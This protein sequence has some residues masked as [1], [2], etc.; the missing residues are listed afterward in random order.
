MNRTWC[1][2]LLVSITMIYIFRSWFIN[3]VCAVIPKSD[4]YVVDKNMDK[5]WH[6]EYVRGYHKVICKCPSIRR[7]PEVYYNDVLVG[8]GSTFW[9]DTWFVDCNGLASVYMTV[10]DN[11]RIKLSNEE[12]E[13]FV[14]YVFRDADYKIVGYSDVRYA[15]SDTIEIKNNEGNRV[16]ILE[17][18]QLGI[19]WTWNVTITDQDHLLSDPLILFGI[20]GKLEFEHDDTDGCN[21]TW[22]MT[23]ISI[24]IILVLVLACYLDYHNQRR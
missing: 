14:S 23:L 3:E 24:S 6:N 11:L 20:I 2:V 1:R 16:A 7:D 8:Y 9:V 17:K 15:L 18:G 10:D 4:M 5:G 19:G 12:E 22:L 13:I 21:M